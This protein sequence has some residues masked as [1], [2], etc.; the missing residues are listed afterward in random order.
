[1]SQVAFPV[2]TSVHD[3]TFILDHVGDP[4]REVIDEC[5]SLKTYRKYV[6]RVNTLKQNTFTN[7]HTRFDRYVL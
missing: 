4:L 1:M 2:K 6:V 7:T 5:R 3:A